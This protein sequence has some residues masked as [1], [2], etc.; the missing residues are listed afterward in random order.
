ML[1]GE[2][3]TESYHY[4]RE[5]NIGFMIISDT[6]RVLYSR[7]ERYLLC[8]TYV[9]TPVNEVFAIYHILLGWKTYYI[10]NPS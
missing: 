10:Y 8:C 2:R 9:H 4:D 6:E 3:Y 1:S 5:Y 7:P